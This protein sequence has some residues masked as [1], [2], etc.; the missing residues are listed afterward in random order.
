MDNKKELILKLSKIADILD[1]DGYFKESQDITNFLAKSAQ[2]ITSYP[3][4]FQLAGLNPTGADYR[5]TAAQNEALRAA[6]SAK[7]GKKYPTFYDA[8]QAAFGSWT[9]NFGDRKINLSGQA[10]GRA[11]ASPVTNPAVS[12]ST[13]TPATQNPSTIPATSATPATQN[14]TGKTSMPQAQVSGIVNSVVSNLNKINTV[15]GQLPQNNSFGQPKPNLAPVVNQINQ[16]INNV[17]QSL[18]PLKGSTIVPEQKSKLDEALKNVNQIVFN[19]MLFLMS[20]QEF[21]QS[22]K[23]PLQQLKASV[24]QIN[25]YSPPTVA[26]R[27]VLQEAFENRNQTPFGQNPQTPFWKG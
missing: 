21:N 25:T 12:Q 2:N 24:D 19:K 27:S 6:I 20:S 5:G 13:A 4:Y 9:K 26:P 7:H 15:V 14:P 10:T 23:A 1:A 8:Y 22:L 11:P 17:V 18:T 16:I 3:N